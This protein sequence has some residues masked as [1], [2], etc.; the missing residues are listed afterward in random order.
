M[1]LLPD[2]RPTALWLFALWT[3][4]CSSGIAADAQP[5]REPDHVVIDGVNFPFDKAIEVVGPCLTS[6]TFE[7]R[8]SYARASLL[9]LRIEGRANQENIAFHLL[10]QTDEDRKKLDALNKDAYYKVR[11]RISGARMSGP[12]RICNFKVEHFEAVPAAPL[13]PADFIG[14]VACFEGVA[15]AKGAVQAQE[16]ELHLIGLPTWPKNIEGKRVWVRGSVVRDDKGW[17]LSTPT[18]KV[19]D[20]ADMVGQE[21]SLDGTLWSLNGHW[22]FN[23]RK[24][25]FN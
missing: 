8:F 1:D 20:L 7:L 22:W 10:A 16:E 23:Y 25:L 24:T 9:G 21:V 2:R 13:K 12:N 17:Q 11:G 6:D 3:A 4:V 18:W 19:V 14:R 5:K 15:E